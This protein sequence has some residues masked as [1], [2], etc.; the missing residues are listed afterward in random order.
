MKRYMEIMRIIDNQIEN[1]YINFNIR[2]K[3]QLIKEMC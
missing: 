3:E 2:Q 1:M